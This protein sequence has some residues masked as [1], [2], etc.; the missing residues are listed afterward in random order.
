MSPAVQR[1]LADLSDRGGLHSEDIA[2]IM[3]VSPATVARWMRGEAAPDLGTRTSIGQL[4]YIV[5]RLSATRSA[6]EVSAWFHAPLSGPTGA[7]AIELMRCGRIADVLAE[8]ERLHP[9]G[10]AR[11]DE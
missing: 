4:H 2:D 8:V 11:E 1:T 10:P 7:S 3:S 6:S 9:D 5:D